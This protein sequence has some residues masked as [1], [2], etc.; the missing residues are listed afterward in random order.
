MYLP[1]S[2]EI[3]SQRKTL[4]T[5]KVIE[6]CKTNSASTP[7]KTVVQAIHQYVD[8]ARNKNDNKTNLEVFY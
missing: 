8:S 5:V 4:S 3:T 7:V 2:V 6:V 1:S